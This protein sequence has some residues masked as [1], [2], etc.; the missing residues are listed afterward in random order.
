MVRAIYTAIVL[1]A[2]LFAAAP[3]MEAKPVTNN[4]RYLNEAQAHI[5]EFESGLD[6]Q[7]LRD[8]YMSIENVILPQEPD[9]K[10]REQLRKS[11]LSVWLHLLQILDRFVDPNFDPDDVPEDLVQP[12]KTTGGVVYPPGADPALIADPAARAEY[13]KAIEANRKKIESYNLQLQLSRLT[14]RVSERADAFLRR[15]YTPSP[16]DRKELK[17]AIDETI[18]DPKRKAHLLEILEPHRN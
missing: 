18:T 6:P 13:E 2:A 3:P 5:K 11:A 7:R 8:A 16:H 12:P 10:T 1:P 14:P 4:Q 9:L 17:S 15:S